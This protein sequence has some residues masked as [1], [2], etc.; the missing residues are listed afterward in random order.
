MKIS[1]CENIRFYGNGINW[2][3][4]TRQLWEGSCRAYL[5]EQVF[6][7]L[8]TCSGKYTL[9]SIRDPLIIDH[10][11]VCTKAKQGKIVYT[12]RLEV[13][14]ILHTMKVIFLGQLKTFLGWS[15]FYTAPNI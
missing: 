11:K 8:E 2:G 14:T 15:I 9:Y 4:L 12:F 1:E 10:S 5:S 6:R 3:P 13:Q 7:E